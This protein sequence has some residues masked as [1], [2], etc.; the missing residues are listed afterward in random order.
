ML[1]RKENHVMKAVFSKG[2]GKSS[3]LITPTDLINIVGKDKVKK[4]ELDK[5]IVDLSRDGY[6]DLVYSDRRGE[7][8]YCLTLTKKGKGFNRDRINFKRNLIF[9]LLLTVGLA[10]VSFI[11][12]L[13]L[14]KIF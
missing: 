1:S 2:S 14:K 4:S 3:L 10:V 6:F 11:I 12:G 5:I 13:I 8:V 7:T 9:R